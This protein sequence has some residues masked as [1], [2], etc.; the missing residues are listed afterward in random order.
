MS[1]ISRGARKIGGPRAIAA[2]VAL[3]ADLAKGGL[4]CK[5]VSRQSEPLHGLEADFLV[6]AHKWVR[7]GSVNCIMVAH[8]HR[9]DLSILNQQFQRDAV[10]QID[11]HRVQAF[12]LAAQGM[13]TQRGMGRVGFQ[14]LQGFSVGLPKLRM[15][16]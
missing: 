4:S 12:M 5:S 8:I 3:A 2:A 7:S 13:Q 14:Q 15:P 6:Q 16:F 11:R 1:G 10:G 9:D